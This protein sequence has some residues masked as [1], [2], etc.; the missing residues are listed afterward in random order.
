MSTGLRPTA[1]ALVGL[2]LLDIGPL[3]GRSALSFTD[4]GGQPTNLFLMMGPNGSGKTTILEAIFTSM[5]LLAAISHPSFGVE[6]L[7][8]GEGG[9]QLDARVVL[10][11]GARARPFLL[12]IVAGRS[13]LLQEWP[14]EALERVEADEHII[15]QFVRRGPA[16][17]VTRSPSTHPAAA[18]FQD[19]IIAHLSDQP[20]DLFESVAGF[21]TVLYFPSNRGIKRPPKEAAITRP[22][23]L[24]YAPAHRFDTDGQSWATSLDNL[25]VWFAWLSDGREDRSRELVNNLVF[26]GTKRLGAVDRQ[27]LFVP[28]EVEASGDR[29]R[30]HQL[31]SGERQLVQLVVRIASHMSGSTIVLIDETEQH[32]HLVMRRRL[33]TIMKEWVRAFGG[34]SFVFTSHQQDT[35]RLLAPMREEP[36]LTKSASL[37]KPRFKIGQ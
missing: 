34:L 5:S 12:S 6:A 35:F 23:G 9:M 18:A 30:L 8:A 4:P 36:G 1:F 28:V 20:Q 7:D 14:Q 15:L 10:D 11:D 17:P 24:A 32:L 2:H 27:N 31:S 33:M 16:E 22:P 29:H 13:G 25:F 37:V 19:A 3:R 26:R 21:P